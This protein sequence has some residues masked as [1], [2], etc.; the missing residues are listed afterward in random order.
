MS[1]RRPPHRHQSPG[2]PEGAGEGGCAGF[3]ALL[4]SSLDGEL[5]GERTAALE[6]HLAACPGCVA[7]KAA[8]LAQADA[9]REAS[10]RALEG[11]SLEG[12]SA[13]V[14]RAIARD[15]ARPGFLRS[16]GALATARLS[17]LWSRRRVQL[18]A[19]VGAV[20]CAGLLLAVSVRPGA[21]APGAPPAASARLSEARAAVESLDVSGASYAVLDLEGAPTTV[22]WI[23]PEED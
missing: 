2:A 12:F 9:L 5:A 14:M 6:A 8:L 1:T 11:L 7:R 15:R 10:A 4:S 22:I 21:R 13:G 20:A 17:E 16:R 3:V 18:L 23:S 19:S